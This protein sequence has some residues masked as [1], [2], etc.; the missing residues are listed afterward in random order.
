MWHLNGKFDIK[1][2]EEC[3]TI[4]EQLFLQNGMLLNIDKLDVVVLSNAQQAREL[5]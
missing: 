3:S 2:L 5:P 1:A 4:V